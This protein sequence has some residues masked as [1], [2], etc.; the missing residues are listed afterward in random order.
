MNHVEHAQKI[1]GLWRRLSGSQKEIVRNYGQVQRDAVESCSI[2]DTVVYLY[3]IRF[4]LR[5][6]EDMD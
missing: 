5:T 2:S 6:T 3:E 1:Q 4:Q